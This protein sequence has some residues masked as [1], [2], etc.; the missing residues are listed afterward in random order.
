MAFIQTIFNIFNFSFSQK[1]SVK[2]ELARK[3]DRLLVDQA[4]ADLEAYLDQ[5]YFDEM[6]AGE[7][8]YWRNGCHDRNASIEARRQYNSA[9]NLTTLIR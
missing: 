4:D 5:L 6:K 8:V 9:R 7:A 2:N 1:N 3:A